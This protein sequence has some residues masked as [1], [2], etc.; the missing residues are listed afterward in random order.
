MFIEAI[1]HH[2][3]LDWQ[4]LINNT[5]SMLIAYLLALPIAFNRENHTRSAGLR[6]F[7]LVSVSAC[8]FMLLTTGAIGN[9]SEQ[10]RVVQGIITGIGFIGGGAILKNGHTVGGTAT[11]AG[12]WATG[13]IGI[14]VAWQ[15]I[16]IAILLSVFTMI[17][18]VYGNK[19]KAA[20]NGKHSEDEEKTSTK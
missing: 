5:V 17:T 19:A 3:D 1:Q 18:L 12:I 10:S 8:A 16:E 20:V 14:A 9:E 2:T 6:T 7:P 4:L 13:A 11:A 15:H